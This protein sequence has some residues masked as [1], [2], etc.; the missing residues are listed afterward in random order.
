MRG[1]VQN[2]RFASMMP[3]HEASDNLHGSSPLALT[4]VSFNDAD[5]RS[6]G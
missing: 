1:D 3:T 2:L 6:V 4:A 5:A